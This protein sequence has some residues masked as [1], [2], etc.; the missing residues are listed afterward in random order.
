MAAA[1]VAG[2]AGCIGGGGESSGQNNVF[3][4]FFGNWSPSDA[5]VNQHSAAT[6]PPWWA[7]N[8]WGSNVMHANQ[9]NEL[10]FGFAEDIEFSDDGKSYTVTY[11]DGWTF[12]DGREITAEDILTER[13]VFNYKQHNQKQSPSSP[14]EVVS[15]D[16]IKIKYEYKCPKN[17]DFIISDLQNEKVFLGRKPYR[18]FIERFEDASSESTYTDIKQDLEEFRLS[19]KEVR[20]KNLGCGLWKPV[21]W[22]GTSITHEKYEDHPRADQTNIETLARTLA[23]HNPDQDADDVETVRRLKVS[24]HHQHL[25]KIADAGLI[26]YDI[27]RKAVY[28]TDVPE[29]FE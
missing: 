19:L 23:E 24:L 12:W 14:H 13:V 5:N 21:N 18:E 20:D 17:K 22:D 29:T 11:E 27:D 10:L 2:V 16:P 25:P 7:G 3:R 26:A 6:G 8:V 1:G 4:S 15:D 28:P 9:N